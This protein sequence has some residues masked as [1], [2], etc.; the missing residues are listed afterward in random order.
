MISATINAASARTM[1]LAD[2]LKDRSADNTEDATEDNTENALENNLDALFD[3]I[4]LFTA[5]PRYYRQLP[6]RASGYA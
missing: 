1:K 6:N 4:L 3:S 5:T 2:N